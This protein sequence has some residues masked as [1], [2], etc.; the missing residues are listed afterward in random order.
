VTEA[1]T[2]ELLADSAVETVAVP[3]VVVEAPVVAL[4]VE[5]ACAVDLKL[6]WF[7]TDSQEFSSLRGPKRL[8][9]LSLLL[10]ES[11]CTTRSASLPKIKMATKLN[12]VFGTLTAPKL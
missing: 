9:S 6:W 2:E 5:E 10:P 3:E 7:P 1:V 8:W 12:T 11:L 4:V